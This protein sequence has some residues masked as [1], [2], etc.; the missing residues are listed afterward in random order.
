MIRKGKGKTGVSV[1]M[2]HL[3]NA[4]RVL[5][6]YSQ[7]KEY[8]KSLIQEYIPLDARESTD[9]MSYH[10]L[11]RLGYIIRGVANAK[12]KNE[13]PRTTSLEQLSLPGFS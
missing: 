9:L 7:N 8:L 1:N 13:K 11:K 10:K 2:P 4:K 6:N 5:K 12:V 3:R